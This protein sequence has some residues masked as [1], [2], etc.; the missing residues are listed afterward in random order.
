MAVAAVVHAPS[1]GAGAG[2]SVWTGS[3]VDAVEVEHYSSLRDM[4][5]STDAVV[6]GQ[7]TAVAPGRVFGY[8]SGDVLHYA[9]ATVR[10]DEVIVGALPAP[11]ASELTLEIPL[12][13]G[14][15]SI[16]AM[17][18]SLPWEESVFFLRDKGESGRAAGLSQELQLAGAG[19]YRLVVFRAVV[20]NEGGRAALIPGD[21]GVLADVAGQPFGEVLGVVREAAR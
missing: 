21:A 4:T 6:R 10:V 1:A 5:Q 2:V 20:V 9:A 18:S 13:D 12:F 15:D 16:A 3:V 14:P 11:D 7:V 17:Q 19:F 8:P